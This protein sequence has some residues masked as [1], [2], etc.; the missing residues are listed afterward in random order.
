MFDRV[1]LTQMW[2]IYLTVAGDLHQLQ[3]RKGLVELVNTIFSFSFMKSVEQ[4]QVPEDESMDY[5]NVHG[6]KLILRT[7]E[8][9]RVENIETKLKELS[10]KGLF[11]VRRFSKSRCHLGEVWILGKGSQ[12]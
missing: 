3:V 9:E 11:H 10:K 2:I 7:I 5:N 12:R 6:V 8:L 4:V 1:G